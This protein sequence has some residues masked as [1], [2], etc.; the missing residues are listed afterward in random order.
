MVQAL[1]RIAFQ[2]GKVY[3]VVL[4][5]KERLIPIYEKVNNLKKF[6]L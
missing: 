6:F 4:E 3:K 1:T 5:A 2:E